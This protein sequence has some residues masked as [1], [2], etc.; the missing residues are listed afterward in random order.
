VRAC[1]AGLARGAEQAVAF[2]SFLCVVLAGSL[3]RAIAY[4]RQS[5]NHRARI[6]ASFGLAA[7]FMHLSIP[8]D[9]AVARAEQ[10][11]QDVRGEGP[12]EAH[13]LMPLS[14]LYAHAGRF[15]EARAASARCRSLLTAA[16]ARLALARTTYAA[17]EIELTAGDP[18][19]AERCWREGHEAFRAMGER[20]TR[21]TL[22]CWLAEALYLQGRLDEAQQMTEEA[23]EL[24]LS[25]PDDIETQALWRATR[26][27]LLARH[28]QFPAA[29]QLIADA[30]ALISP[31][32]WMRLRAHLLVAEAE[33]RQLAGDRRQAAASLHAALRI[34]EDQRTA[35]LAAQVKAALTSLNASP[36]SEPA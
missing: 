2:A 32:V 35:P 16:A 23:E 34:Y 12:A 5:G 28:R 7:T 33:V 3:E 21:S 15:A 19:A 14:V 9:A 30:Q 22:A 1:R 29:R 25:L 4:A 27:K 17:G 24:S 31:T 6:Q 8:A 26:A 13:V 11:L 20:G 36:G 18:A 10:L